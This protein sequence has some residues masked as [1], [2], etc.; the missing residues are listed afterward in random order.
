MCT[1]EKNLSLIILASENSFI[2]KYIHIY[3]QL[4]DSQLKKCILKICFSLTFSLAGLGT[5]CKKLEHCVLITYLHFL[6]RIKQ[7]IHNI[8]S[9]SQKKIIYHIYTHCH[10]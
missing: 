4:N 6:H 8:V 3:F 2:L 10:L 5:H 7:Y 9:V 1:A